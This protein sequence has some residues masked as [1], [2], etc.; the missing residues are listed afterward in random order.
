MGL[1]HIGLLGGVRVVFNKGH[2]I[3]MELIPCGKEQWCFAPLPAKPME[4]RSNT[5]I[6]GP[7]SGSESGHGHGLGLGLGSRVTG[8]WAV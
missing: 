8:Q 1:S 2:L 7:G 3:R 4:L 6:P 5:P